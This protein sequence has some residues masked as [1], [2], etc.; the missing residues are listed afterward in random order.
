[1]DE[2]DNLGPCSQAVGDGDEATVL[3]PVLPIE[4]SGVLEERAEFR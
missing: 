4:E 3:N 1:V 2:K